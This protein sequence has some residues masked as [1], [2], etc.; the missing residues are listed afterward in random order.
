[1]GTSK[2]KIP[3]TN[4]FNDCQVSNPSSACCVVAEYLRGGTLKSY[5]YK[6]RREKIPYKTVVQLA[7][8]LARGFGLVHHFVRFCYLLWFLTLLILVLLLFSFCSLSYL[9]SKRIV[10]RDVKTENMLLGSQR[11]LKVTDFGVARVEAQ[12]PRDMT[13]ETGTIGYMAPEVLTL[14]ITIYNSSRFLIETMPLF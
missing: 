6:N 14:F 3:S 9:H 1:M 2:L 13:G 7:L 10:H 5:L 4:S 11:T 12:N 8:D